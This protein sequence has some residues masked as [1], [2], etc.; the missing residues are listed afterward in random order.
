MKITF[1][2]LFW[3]GEDSETRLKNLNFAWNKLKEFSEF[4]GHNDIQNVCLLFDFSEEKKINDSIHIPYLK[5]EYKRSEKI[6]KVLEYN[7]KNYNPELICF[8]DSD[9]FF[10]KDQYFYLLHEIKNFNKNDVMVSKLQDIQ[11]N[12][13]INFENNYTEYQ[14]KERIITGLGAFFLINFSILFNIG[15]FDERFIV[16]G[17]E[18]DDIASRLDNLGIQRYY[19]PI[20]FYH[21]PHESLRTNT[22]NTEQYKKQY[23]I[24]YNNDI[25]TK[26]SLITNKYLII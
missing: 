5:N 13:A 19:I 7:Y 18:D 14:V 10:N 23:K 8:L 15:G 25:V 22:I 16:W 26:F 6:N 1:N 9:V 11:N 12:D 24:I 4:C 2:M 20:I 17:G 3:D 21:L